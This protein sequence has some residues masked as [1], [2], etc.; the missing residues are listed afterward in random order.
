MSVSGDTEIEGD[1][2]LTLKWTSWDGDRVLLA[3]YTATGTITNDD[4]APP[5]PPATVTI[6]DAQADEGDALSFRVS[7]DK[8]VPGG[9]TVTPSF[10]DGTATEGTDYTENTA[11]LSFSGTAGETQSF[12]V[13]TSE[14][15]DIEDNE[16]FTV[17]VSV[18]GTSHDV[19]ASDTATGT[20]N[21]DDD[22]SYLILNSP[23][24]QEGD[25]GTT[26]LMFTA[27]LD[28]TSPKTITASY[29]VLSESGDSA[30]AGTDYTATSGTVTFAPGET[31]KTIAVSVMGDT[32]V[33][34]DET[35]T[36]KWDRV[37]ERVVGTLL[38]NRHD[39]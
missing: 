36:V 10:S 34:G 25:S 35:L 8:E 17:S 33:E 9:F 13:S 32:A 27:T 28:R 4:T 15:E 31:S 21:N 12:S 14:D 39:H 19:T 22:W 23:S 1:E 6:A 3:S 38:E 5:P 7:L 26:T 11:S 29:E 16:T 20:I 18:S 37:G 24:V 2:T 30:T